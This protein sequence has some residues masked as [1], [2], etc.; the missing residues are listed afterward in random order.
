MS[1]SSTVFHQPWWMEI[2]CEGSYRAVEIERG[3]KLVGRLPYKISK[4]GLGLT[5]IGMPTMSHVLGP[6]LISGHAE[7]AYSNSSMQFSITRDLVAQL[8]RAA[9][10]SFR[11]HG[12][13]ANTLSF[14]TLGFSNRVD[15]TVEIAPD[16]P[17]VLW[18]RMRDKTR[19]V[20]RRA[21]EV[22]TVSDKI[23]GDV[24]FEFY[25]ANLNRKGLRNHYKK[26]VVLALITESVKR[27]SGR[28]L[29]AVDS[30]GD[31]QAA[32]FTVWD[33]KYDFYLMSTRKEGAMNG[34]VNQLIW[35]AIKHASSNGRTFDMDGLHIR[36]SR[37]SNFSLLAG[38]GGNI[39]PRYVVWRSSPVVEAFKGAKALL[40]F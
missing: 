34:A 24:F 28:I 8:P 2:A 30:D 25:D 36:D 32:I 38:F 26:E 22:L 35:S 13:F 9:H 6:A 40:F 11:L 1:L 19:N 14:D 5:V 23:A 33:A 27:G 16:T 37:I 10:V 39:R 18:S 17:E 29:A 21:E 12:G 20:I 31:L 3:G 4:R 15:F 7:S